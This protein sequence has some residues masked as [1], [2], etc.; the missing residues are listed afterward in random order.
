MSK[1][2]I[3]ERLAVRLSHDDAWQSC[4]TQLRKNIEPLLAKDPDFFPDYTIHGIDHIN[5]C[6]DIADHLI[7]FE[8]LSAEP[9]ASDL[10]T[11]RDVAFLICGIMLHDMGMFLRP[12]G[13]RKLVQMDHANDAFGGASW[14]KEWS[15]YVDRMKRLSQEKMRYHFGKVIPV[16]EDC[17]N[18][19][20]T[21]DNK[22]II[23]E[24]LRQHHARLAHEFAVGILPGSDD[25]DLFENTGLKEKDR[26]LIGLLARSHGMAIRDTEAYVEKQIGKGAKPYKTPVFYLMTVLRTADAL[27]ADEQRAPKK[28][29]KQQKIDV[30]ISVEEWTWNQCIDPD[31][32]DWRMDQKNRYIEA[33]PKS[34]PQYVQ[35]DKWLKGVQ[36]DLDLCWSIL[37]EK[38]SHDRYRLSIHRVVSNIQEPG[39]RETMNETF[40]PREARITANPEIVKLMME[41]LY[42]NDPSYGVRELLQNAVDAC[43]ERE[44]WEKNNKKGDP[45]YKGLV[46]IRIEN[47]IFTITDNGMG[48]NEDVL[49]NYYL[50]AGSSYRSSEEWKAIHAPEGL[51]QVTRTGRFGVGFL[52][53]FLLGD[54]VEVQTQ[55]RIPPKKLNPR[56]FATDQHGYSFAFGQKSNL[57][58]IRRIKRVN[59]HSPQ[60]DD[61]AGTTIR[62]HLRNGIA[63]R[64]STNS[65]WRNW[66]VFDTPE[67]HYSINGHEFPHSASLFRSPEK[68]TN[69]FSLDS[70]TYSVFQ[71]SPCYDPDMRRFY[72]NGIRVERALPKDLRNQGLNIF[73]PAVSIVDNDANLPLNLARDKLLDFPEK[74]TLYQDLFRYYIAKLLMVRWDTSNCFYWNVKHGFELRVDKYGSAPFLFSGYGYTVNYASFLS[75]LGISEYNILYRNLDAAYDLCGSLTKEDIPVEFS[76]VHGSNTLSFASDILKT[77]SFHH[78]KDVIGYSIQHSWDTLAVNKSIYFERP[79]HWKKL[80]TLHNPSS[81]SSFI[82]C[83][84]SGKISL[85]VIS[86]AMETSHADFAMHIIPEK[87]R[88][89][90]R[91]NGNPDSLFVRTMKEML[92]P[93]PDDPDHPDKNLWIPMDMSERRKKFPKAFEYID[94]IGSDRFLTETC[95]MILFSAEAAD[96]PLEAPD[97]TEDIAGTLSENTRQALLNA[98]NSPDPALSVSDLH[99]FLMMLSDLDHDA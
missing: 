80:L 50:S 28:L 1:I 61:P 77:G 36:A 83:R 38:Y 27:D 16:T 22:R 3:P 32:C 76:Y 66:F 91:D 58:D 35:L 15:D 41:P 63:E 64:L 87:D 8:T 19:T 12:D 59:G 72:C 24:F 30:P 97:E 10:L 71:W 34:S 25:T 40:L 17:V 73:P 82:C 9:K 13:V 79:Q 43:L 26:K 56:S 86:T 39:I 85:Q 14:K 90:L 2:I 99:H 11:P 75:A 49:L 78:G 7:D 52:A 88:T 21:D 89:F 93:Y 94:R 96:L 47:D 81:M 29:E 65:L 44:R 62:I 51:S 6:L 84:K 42:G 98:L 23:G 60:V 18:H 33:A 54:S 45:N 68:N 55:H 20:D 70:E 53:A 57:L 37:A 95:D 69:W 31:A 92:I 74:E 67:I 4:V 46:D 5:R 48:M